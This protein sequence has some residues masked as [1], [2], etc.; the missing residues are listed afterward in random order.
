MIN[1]KWEEKEDVFVDNEYEFIFINCI[2][3]LIIL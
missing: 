2:N 3:K 1:I